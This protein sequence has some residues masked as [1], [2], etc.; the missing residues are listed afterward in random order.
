MASYK[1][2]LL[3]NACHT[4]RRGDGRDALFCYF[5]DGGQG[6][7]VKTLY[8]TDLRTPTEIWKFAVVDAVH[9]CGGFEVTTSKLIPHGE[10]ERVEFADS[11]MTV[12]ARHGA[13]RL[14][15]RELDDC[16]KKPPVI[17]TKAYQIDFTFDGNTYRVAA[18]SRDAARV[19]EVR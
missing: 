5:E 3:T 19:F 17:A 14:T 12:Y 6:Y 15:Q 4:I 9:W 18:G 13:R 8:L 7:F 11:G 10:I 2:G 1:P 16:S